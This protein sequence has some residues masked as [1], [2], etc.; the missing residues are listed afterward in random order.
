[1]SL[2][3]DCKS[4]IWQLPQDQCAWQEVQHYMQVVAVMMLCTSI[5][6]WA[7]ACKTSLIVKCCI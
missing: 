1:M 2:W 3:A 4:N 5:Y 7:L 6:T